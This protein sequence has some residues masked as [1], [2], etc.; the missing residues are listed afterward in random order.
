MQLS[1]FGFVPKY[2]MDVGAFKGDWTRVCLDIF[3]DGTI[4]CIE[5]QEV[6][7]A[8][9]KKLASEHSNVR[10]FQTLLGK[11]EHKNIPFKEVGSGSSVLLNSGEETRRPMT[12]ID[13]LIEEG[14]CKPP[15]LLKLDVQ[16]Y[17]LE[18]LEG[19]TRNFDVCQVIQI[20]ISLLPIVK[21]API[22]HEV[23]NYLYQ[24]G[25]VMFDVDELIRA[26]S[27]GAVWQIDALFCRFDSPLRATRVWREE[28]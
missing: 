12:T 3:P 7:Q 24:R 6:P 2:I 21:G 19:Y 18:I 8:E 27:D 17:E 14:Y 1:R 5:P 9:L 15:Q 20:E 4:T 25:F 16:G 23:V 28:V 10:I 26:P 13:A 22:L 11:S